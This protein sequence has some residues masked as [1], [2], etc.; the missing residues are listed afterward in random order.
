MIC[1]P[2]SNQGR[3]SWTLNDNNIIVKH[4]ISLSQHFRNNLS[5]DDR[6]FARFGGPRPRS[7]KIGVLTT[8]PA[9]TRTMRRGLGHRGQDGAETSR[10]T[11]GLKVEIISRITQNK[12]RRAPA[13]HAVGSTRRR[14]MR[15]P[16]SRRP[17]G[18]SAAEV[19]GAD[20]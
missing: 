5:R 12:R 2:A 3:S 20:A 7:I 14:S 19:C 6:V 1:C 16:T 11:S 10:G 13:S 15:S 8:R 17:M 9:L 18:I 4:M